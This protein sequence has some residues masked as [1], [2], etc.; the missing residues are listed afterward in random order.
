[1]TESE[2]EVMEGGPGGD[3]KKIEMVGVIYRDGGKEGGKG[4]MIE[5][6]CDEDRQG[7]G[8]N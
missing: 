2:N 5:H 7:E 6:V 3:R 8:T 4:S 1:M